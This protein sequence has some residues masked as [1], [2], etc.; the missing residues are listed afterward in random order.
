MAQENPFAQ[1][2][3]PEENPFAKYNR[4]S[5][6]L[7]PPPEQS[8][9]WA[10]LKTSFKQLPE[11]GW[12]L[13][14]ITAAGLESA[15]G[16]GGV[17]TAAKQYAIGKYKT[18]QDDIAKDSRPNYELDTAWE[19]AK[20]GDFGALVDWA[21]YGVGYSLGQ[22]AQ[23]LATAGVGK[24]GAQALLKPAVEKMAGAMVDKEVLSIAASKAGMAL[25]EDEVRR[26]AVKNVAGSLGQHA[27]MAATAFGMEGGEI[28]GDLAAST[29]DGNG[30]N[31]VLTGT[32]LARGLGATLL[33]GSMEYGEDLLSL[34]L[35]KGAG[36][37]HA[38][39]FKATPGLA[40]KA[41]RTATGMAVAAPIEA[42]TEYFQTGV[43]NY[44]KGEEENI[45]PF[46]QSEKAQRDAF[47]SAGLGAMGG[48]VHAAIGGVISRPDIKE[49]AAAPT[50][51]AAI[52][53]AIQSVDTV[54]TGEHDQIHTLLA[55]FTS[56]GRQD[57]QVAD[58]LAQQEQAQDDLMAAPV[59]M[60]TVDAMHIQ[61]QN[62]LSEMTQRTGT[63]LQPDSSL[64]IVGQEQPA[65][66]TAPIATTGA[67]NPRADVILTQAA[68]HLN[69]LA[70]EV[71]T[72]ILSKY[73][74]DQQIT[75][76]KAM[77]ALNPAVPAGI[78]TP[79]T[80]TAGQGQAA[81]EAER[82]RVEAMRRS[83][84]ALQAEA[85]Q[86]ELAPA[87][88]VTPG[89]PQTA[90]RTDVALPGTQSQ[91]AQ[92]ETK[93]G[94]EPL[95]VGGRATALMSNAELTTIVQDPK[96]HANT[97]RA[98]QAALGARMSTGRTEPVFL[99]EPSTPRTEPAGEAPV[100]SG[101]PRA[102]TTPAAP[103]IQRMLTD[104]PADAKVGT[105]TPESLPN[106]ARSKAT[107]RMSHH[108]ARI[109]KTLAGMLGRKVE[110]FE[111]SHPT[112]EGIY[113]GG[114]TLYINVD[115]T[116]VDALAVAG[117]EFTHSLRNSDPELYDKAH[118]AVVA[119]LKANPD[120]A[121]GY[122]K[123]YGAK[124]TDTHEDLAHELLADIGG[125]E[126]RSG[127]FWNDVFDEVHK[128][129]N[130]G[131]ARG[132]I[133][134]LRDA[135]VAFINKLIA[136]TPLQGFAHG[137]TREE[138]VSV[139][140]TVVKATAQSL[141]RA[142][143]ARVM[144]TEETW[145]RGTG[146]DTQ[147]SP[148]RVST[149]KSA[150]ER[151]GRTLDEVR[152]RVAADHNLTVSDDTTVMVNGEPFI[153]IDASK[154]G[155]GLLIPKATATEQLQAMMER[156]VREAGLSS[157]LAAKIVIPS[158]GFFDTAFRLADGARYWYEL[159]AY[160]FGKGYFGLSA[161]RTEHLIDIIAATSGGQK[162]TDNLRVGVAAMAQQ[163]QNKP[164]TVGVREAASLSQSLSPDA[165]N[166]HKFGNFADTMQLLADLRPG[167]K[168]LPTIDLQMAAVFGMP[169]AE[170]AGNPVMY[171]TLSRFLIMLRDAQN[172]NLSAGAQPYESWQMQAL[173]WV[174]QRGTADPDSFDI[175]MPK[176]VQ[177]LKNAGIPVP[178]GRI[179][180][181]TL[182]DPRTPAVL[183][184][185]S[186]FTSE[187]QTATVET[188]TKLTAVGRDSSALFDQL[189]GI[190]EPWAQKLRDQFVAIQRRT[191]RALG[192]KI[193]LPN[194]KT[195]VS[196]YVGQLMAWAAGKEVYNWG[197]AR[198]DTHGQGFFA[199]EVSPNLRIPLAVT[200]SRGKT[201]DERNILLTKTQSEF[202]LGVLG[203]ELKQAAMAA[204]QFVPAEDGTHGTFS[205]LIQNYSKDDA[206]A[207]ALAKISNILGRPINYSH[208]PNG[209][210]ID[211]N[212]GGFDP[213]TDEALIAQA[214]TDSF[215]P[216]VTAVMLPMA[217][218]SHYL[219][220]K[221]TEPWERSYDQAIGTFF[222]ELG[223]ETK[224]S[225]GSRVGKDVG[226]TGRDLD[227]LARIR[228]AIGDIAAEQAREFKQWTKDARAV[229]D[230]R[231]PSNATGS[232]PAGAGVQRSNARGVH[233]SREQR[234]SLSSSA[235]GQ[236]A[237][238]EEL[239]RVR[240]AADER[241]KHRIY[242][243]VNGGRGITPET[244]V[245]AH[246]HEADL[247][248]LYDLDADPRDLRVGA[249][250]DANMI[251]SRV[252]DA[253]F[254]G[255][256]SPERGVAVLIGQR[257]V[258]V[259]YK[260][261]GARPE[262]PEVGR[263]TPSDYGRAQQ[264]LAA[265]RDLPTGKMSGADWKR[266]VPEADLS[267]LS[268]TESYY[269]DQILAKPAPQ[270][271]E[272]QHSIARAVGISPDDITTNPGPDRLIGMVNRS[273]DGKLRYILDNEGNFHFWD[274]YLGHHPAGAEASGVGYD[275][276]RTGWVVREKD[277]TYQFTNNSGVYRDNLLRYMTGDK[278]TF[279]V[280]GH[281]LV[282]GEEARG[283]IEQ[284]LQHSTARPDTPAFRKWY[285][286]SPR[287]ENGQP[288]VWYHGTARDISVFQPK[289][290][291]AIF[292]TRDPN[293]AGDFAQMSAEWI[294][295][296]EWTNVAGQN[297]MPVYVRHERTFDPDS[298]ADILRLQ[299]AIGD[300]WE[301]PPKRPGAEGADGRP[302]IH[303]IGEVANGAWMA[304]ESPTVQRFIRDN[305]DSFY[306]Y[307]GGNKNLAVFDS[308][309]VKS[310]SG[311]RGTYDGA[312]PDIS[313][314]TAR[315]DTQS[316][317]FKRWARVDDI[318]EYPEDN[319]RFYKDGDGVVVRAYHGFNGD[320]PFD[321]FKPLWQQHLTIP[322]MNIKPGGADYE[323]HQKA[324]AIP[325]AHFFARNQDVAESY[326][327]QFKT[328]GVH[329]VWIRM[330]NPVVDEKRDVAMDR[331]EA[332][333]SR[334]GAIFYDTDSAGHFAGIVYVV[335]AP[336]QIKS[337]TGNRG[338]YDPNDPNIQ[339]STRRDWYYS[340]LENAVSAIPP[341]V[342]NGNDMS[343]WLQS[344]AAKLGVKKDEI[345]WSGLDDWLKLQGRNKVTQDQV[346]QFL[347]E[348]GVKVTDVELGDLPAV[349]ATAIHD[350]ARFG[351]YTV[352]A[353]D[354]DD[355]WIIQHQDPQTRR[356]R[357]V[358][359]VSSDWAAADSIN[360]LTENNSP[361]RY[362]DYQL[363]GG[364]NYKEMLITLP[365]V[366]PLTDEQMAMQ[367][368]D[369][370]FDEL[371]ID[372]REDVRRAV[373][374]ST[375]TFKSSHFNQPNI[376]AHL[377]FNERT[378][379]TGAKVMFLEEVQSDWGEKGRKE[380]FGVKTGFRVV[381]PSGQL[382]GEYSTEA[383]ARDALSR[384]KAGS[385]VEPSDQTYGQ[386][387]PQAPFVTDTKAWVGLGLKRA[388]AY[389]VDHGF[390]R[391][392]WTTGDQQ[393]A[394]YDLSKQVD[395]IHIQ[396]NDD[397]TRTVGVDA[398]GNAKYINMDVSPD[399]RVAFADSQ[400]EL[401]G[402]RLDD[403]IGKEAADKVMSA[404][405][406]K[407][408]SGLDLKVGGEGMTKFY[409]HSDPNKPIGQHTV[410]VKN[411]ATGEMV[412]E[413]RDILPM[414]TVVAKELGMKVES[415][416]LAERDSGTTVVGDADLD[417][418]I[419]RIA[420]EAFGDEA[421]PIRAPSMRPTSEQPGFTITP[422]VREAV[423]AAGLPLFSK[424]RIDPRVKRW[425]DE[426]KAGRVSKVT[427]STML[428]TKPGSV[429]N[430][431]GIYRPIAI[432]VE[433]AIHAFKH[434][435]IT[436][437][438]VASL[439]DLLDRPR[440][441]IQHKNGWRVITDSRD[442]EGRPIAVALTNM[443]DKKTV[444]VT[445]VS[446]VFG[447][448]ES[449]SEV[450]TA[451]LDGKAL[452]LQKGE[453]ARVRGLIDDAT[454][455]SGDLQS[456]PQLPIPEG[457]NPPPTRTISEREVT[458]PSDGGPVKF[459]L[460]VDARELLTG[461]AFSTTRIIG[462]SGRPYT[463]AQ[464]ALHK[465]VG[466]EVEHLTLVERILKWANKN[467]AQGIVDQFA[468]VKEL[469]QTAYRLMR[470]SKGAAG[471]FEAFMKHGKLS[472]KD[473]TYDADTTG[474]VIQHVF[475]PL[476]KETTDFMYWI[477]GNRAERLAMEGKERLFTPAEIAAAKSLAD[478]TIDFDYV[479]QNGQV[480]RDRTLIY[481][482]SLTK[483][484]EFNKN[485]MD[486]AE[487]SGLIDGASRHLWE[488]EFYVP[489]YRLMED[490]E[491]GIRGMNIKQ[492]V[493][494][495]QAFKKLKGGTEQLN[496]LLQNTLMNWAHLI[497]AA[498]KNR[499][500]KATLEAAVA[501]G[502]ARPAI[503][504]EKNI[505]WYQDGAGKADY[506]VDDPHLLVALNGLDY[507]GMRGPMM[508][509]LSA[510]KH[511]LTMGVTASPFFKVR[512]LIRD[513]VQAIGTSGLSY[514]VAD[515][516]AKGFALTNHERQEY[517]S[518]LAGGALIRFG[519]MLEGNEVARTRQL[520]KQGAKD[521]SILD[522][523]GKVQ[524]FY[525]KFLEPAV[526]AYN[527][528]GN[529]GEEINRMSLY[530]QLIKQGVSHGE[531]A[532]QARDLMDFS[533][534]GSFATI[535]FLT[536]V[537]PFMNARLQG[538]YKLGR[539][540]KEDPAKMAVVTGMVAL[541]SLALLMAF[542]GDDDW[543]KR[544]DWDRD[545]YWWF[546]FAGTAYRI[547]KPFELGAVGTLAERSAELIFDKE[548]T[549]KRFRD[550]M[551]KVL[552]NQLS[553][554]PTPQMIKPILDI[555]ANKDSFSGRPIETMAMQRLV[556][557]KRYN[558]ETT[559]VARGASTAV[560]GYLSPV[561][562]DALVRG[563]FSWLGAFAMGSA[564]MAVRAASN[565][566]TKPALDY[567]KFATGG[568][569]ADTDGAGSRYVS[570]MY[571]QATQMEQA[572]ATMRQLMKEGKVQEAQD[573][574]TD[575]MELLKGYKSV[576][577]MKRAESQITERIRMI[578][579]SD[580]HP[581]E[582]RIL[583]NKLRDQQSNIAKRLFTGG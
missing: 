120:R 548:M 432:D 204:S 501:L 320:R 47:N 46:N 502:A 23:V 57:V 71:Q 380:G 217:Y 313:H 459:M 273:E 314:S 235:F 299:Q 119:L 161:N 124:A 11:L 236:G 168:P 460:P 418:E 436:A 385:V 461:V 581:A 399:G 498:A 42:A 282:T 478:G 228:A 386:N 419:D 196:S 136:A 567:W 25:G 421:A 420:A 208:L 269:K 122:R 34:G 480:T 522:N 180:E 454:Q 195:R 68:T 294:S 28:G 360:E 48:G 138:L 229:Y 77:D 308:T 276:T 101:E 583:I 149:K 443:G 520:I 455:P 483:F 296:N 82:Q 280:P 88:V 129:H 437:D 143:R 174:E 506:V 486:M 27:A 182:A 171:E 257:N 334:D 106:A 404:S 64:P 173:L 277:G 213:M 391:I 227:D 387:T 568:M 338:T 98:A 45:L 163:T 448:N 510:T 388:I 162:P 218:D 383:D 557:E 500:A 335:R 107:G 131:E 186:K 92:E 328:K 187:A 24:V 503:T 405:S 336:T 17:A 193:K 192:Q 353:S 96:A 326:A 450:V 50:A 252:L 20:N 275:H 19:K 239:A 533:M 516:L 293:F 13:A 263:D 492:G 409:G 205:V 291:N 376:L 215:G 403:V 348:N 301:E 394:R 113:S 87:P 451:L 66:P 206:P 579:R 36:V 467:W 225:D 85:A 350:G 511:W 246:A 495:Q 428:I 79:A 552:G 433:H 41:A 147:E 105:V 86:Q 349:T 111:S 554:N 139:R 199:G 357:Q 170:I 6:P 312:D 78:V 253:G 362:R 402:K 468:P 207:D 356:I 317:E 543:K 513:S 531:A 201:F 490:N 298:K 117:H 406:D 244:G 211:I 15:A 389:A 278:L 3:T 442:P 466:R 237:A 100:P 140:D 573:F 359:E 38:N 384:A 358:D 9:V 290:A 110:F 30:G 396:I 431:V 54:G 377:R 441:V 247:R 447:A 333:P 415:V 221:V 549:G 309:Q 337:A 73:P 108:T 342:T 545:N 261:L 267:H 44:G 167:V 411:K 150:E 135:I 118:A 361:V 200:S 340:Q 5:E 476:G 259:E 532:L 99:D 438:D 576:E 127:Q 274:A 305:Y 132:I 65:A 154:S 137:F 538:M 427:N 364:E 541:S 91:L 232:G 95:M 526:A 449:A 179:T 190:N 238:S 220:T 474:G 176:I 223:N 37:A 287:D 306:V 121:E 90:P 562:I 578:E 493:I 329:D 134:K 230:R 126:W 472:I 250:G 565:E 332:D 89:V 473:G 366:E 555:Y 103:H 164:V 197:A 322:W 487:Q 60:D 509:A 61:R 297:V 141:I 496:D 245:G 210:R 453:V 254:D 410:K 582:K 178:G 165:L 55:E 556:S 559:M 504:G 286:D 265:R 233:Y 346:R 268:D 12:G 209:W 339:H 368:F 14:S 152:S 379:E 74:I 109:I 102:I 469:S 416:Q 125:N 279:Y 530:D 417:A 564:D 458:V 470:Q 547:P 497:D 527:E 266:M 560:G 347:S 365:R 395:A 191:M 371:N 525:D 216:A 84:P 202:V 401:N 400:P 325:E 158:Q 10:G 242:F 157:D 7:A 310:A 370:R 569:I 53:A 226:S 542:S 145:A 439:P 177:Q 222:K 289:Q 300:R 8:S 494:R 561:Q 304:I 352:Y 512:N 151:K 331:M 83:A 323:Y 577:A 550:V 311:N 514:N 114:K 489:F 169:H 382:F 345:K 49:I 172:N 153:D 485:V 518:A 537:V 316:P 464:Q 580:K 260:G 491:G 264:A 546:K 457:A 321:E 194:R 69:T 319:I 75:I 330:E 375:T 570:Q 104:L 93:A 422:A 56:L 70:P 26:L 343:A 175:G 285:G 430:G 142:E 434:A 521:S 327:D 284:Q 248:N 62:A 189:Q 258:P 424:A 408:L 444:K 203:K 471:A 52:D 529:R 31:T 295:K 219:V 94:T 445:G 566:P 507:A 390:D 528:L 452:Y 112:S 43:E 231:A 255:T 397:G 534:Q 324:K 58:N 288:E 184:P 367:M 398:H 539:A 115:S 214:V 572:Y 2:N 159:S 251:E 481:K 212:I 488:H 144:G 188:R 256:V 440:A 270:L 198:V 51:D 425:A 128:Q 21:G 553:M 544:E 369:R 116:N 535:R 574:R 39:P 224:K 181:T 35:L 67:I 156:A 241:L 185:S 508:D 283:I 571:E 429:L 146:D 72:Q 373:R 29:V 462:D 374:A 558:A 563:Y 123:Y 536:Q 413:Q 517:V 76:R 155:P 523:E 40:G 318:R 32:Q 249:R 33:A 475:Q 463:P 465:K 381:E 130:P 412:E 363:P 307:E 292:L 477:A 81:I 524:Q 446:T 426:V 355:T 160:G 456:G 392:A 479:M 166:T 414:V 262:V 499:A 97:R 484:N 505:V 148:A 18:W 59:T 344:N 315:V 423:K 243:Y 22:G 183:A 302:S 393:A 133:T 372:N 63:G 407:T 303:R 234:E 515:N 540:A 378:D 482:D 16:E 519:T 575:N 80:Q 240:S 354:R 341:K 281:E 1:Y 551:L 271:A 272:V 435:E 4:Q 351:E